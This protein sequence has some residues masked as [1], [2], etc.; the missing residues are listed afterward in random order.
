MLN[1]STEIYLY[2][3]T[4][5]LNRKYRQHVNCQEIF[6]IGKEDQV[7]EINARD[8]FISSDGWSFLAAGL[9]HLIYIIYLN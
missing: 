9:E 1:D 8:P 3:F 7:V 5:K 2:A 6:Y 4:Y